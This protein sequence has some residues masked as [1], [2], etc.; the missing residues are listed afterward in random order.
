MPWSWAD[1]ASS[2]A[3]GL[4]GGGAN[5][6]EQFH[7]DTRMEVNLPRSCGRAGSVTATS[8]ENSFSSA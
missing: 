3:D 4:D 1:A 8:V 7:Y 2:I 6:D 5:S